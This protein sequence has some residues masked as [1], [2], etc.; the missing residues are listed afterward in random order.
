MAS[1]ACLTRNKSPYLPDLDAD[2]EV[3][4]FEPF[5]YDQDPS[6]RNY[7][8]SGL[9]LDGF[10]PDTFSSSSW[11]TQAVEHVRSQEERPFNTETSLQ[12]GSAGS[13][14]L[15][16]SKNFASP[17]IF[18][19]DGCPPNSST[20]ERSR[21]AGTQSVECTECQQMFDSLHS[22]EQ[23][24]KKESHKIW[25]CAEKKCGK[26]YPRR[27]TL[28]RHQLKHSAKGHAC[29][30]CQQ[31]DKRKVFKRRDHLAEHI[32]KRHSPSTDGSNEEDPRKQEALQDIVKSLETVLGGN[33][34]V[35]RGLGSTMTGLSDS[36]MTSVAETIA[37]RIA[38]AAADQSRGY[39][40]ARK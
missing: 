17:S 3:L 2:H 8:T 33:H 36:S 39:D 27:D 38:Q 40:E 23:H 21:G 12:D 30:K 5:L 22:L 24:T 19:Y 31:N 16:G 10:V 14:E 32:R 34:Q 1:I 4:P 18:Q 25:R 20:R 6:Y 7:E 9:V 15:N 11:P 37:K 13:F 35:L 28:S 26:A 29:V